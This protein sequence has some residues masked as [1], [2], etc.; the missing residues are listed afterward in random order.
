MP[1]QLP[2]KEL[3]LFILSKK[4]LHSCY[5]VTN[6]LPVVVR[7]TFFVEMRRAALFVYL[8]VC[9]GLTR[10]S[11]KKKRKWYRMAKDQ[12]V[13]IDAIVEV[14]VELEYINR[15]QEKEINDLMSPCYT[16]LTE[17]TGAKKK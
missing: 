12:L 17:L 2:H 5:E 11:G 7:K 10:S 8:D 14:L 6:D 3:D 16:L 4:L 1:L 9:R 15:H 13:I